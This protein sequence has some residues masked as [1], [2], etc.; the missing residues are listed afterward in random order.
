MSLIHT[1]VAV[2]RCR[3]Q[4]GA[5]G[6]QGRSVGESS[7]HAQAI[8]RRGGGDC[9]SGGN[10]RGPAKVGRR[11]QG[12][13]ATRG[14]CEAPRL[15]LFYMKGIVSFS[16]FVTLDWCVASEHILVHSKPVTLVSTV[17]KGCK[18]GSMSIVYIIVCHINPST[19]CFRN[20]TSRVYSTIIWLA[21]AGTFGP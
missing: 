16:A 11:A 1:N 13:D 21:H 5:C 6:C 18:D 7:S 8:A 3:D 2:F 4:E 9:C 14:V 12:R 15:L 17:V 10:G 20:E 19:I